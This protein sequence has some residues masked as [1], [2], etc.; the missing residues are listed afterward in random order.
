MK[1]SY[2]KQTPKAVMPCSL[3][4]MEHRHSN[5]VGNNHFKPTGHVGEGEGREGEGGVEV[6]LCYY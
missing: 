4:N 3:L 1:S 6:K 2:I 5:I